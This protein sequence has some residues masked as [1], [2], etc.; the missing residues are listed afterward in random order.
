MT[1]ITKTFTTMAL[2]AAVLTGTSL[3]FTNTTEAA[4]HHPPVMQ[5]DQ[6]D[7]QTPPPPQKPHKQHKPQKHHEAPAPEWQA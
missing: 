6:Q 1:K 3:S 2:C 5:L 7:P 4:V